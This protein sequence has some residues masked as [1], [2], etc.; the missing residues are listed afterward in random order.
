M[1]WWLFNRSIYFKRRFFFFPSLNAYNKTMPLLHIRFDVCTL[2]CN[3]LRE[4]LPIIISLWWLNSY[5]HI[6]FFIQPWWL[7]SWSTGC[8]A[9]FFAKINITL[10]FI[11]FSLVSLSIS[12]MNLVKC[13]LWQLPCRHIRISHLNHTHFLLDEMFT[14]TYIYIIKPVWEISV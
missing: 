9:I 12:K 7:G 2:H 13:M 3:I 11:I 8:F 1:L 10:D 14:F 4:V 5:N 6:V